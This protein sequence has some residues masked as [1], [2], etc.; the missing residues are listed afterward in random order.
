M[1][2]LT[3]VKVPSGWREPAWPPTRRET[4]TFSTANGDFD[5]NLTNGFPTTG[6]FGN[7]FLKLSTASGL[8]V[9]DYFEMDNQLQENSTDQDLGSGSVPLLPDLS[10]GAN[11]MHL[12]VGAGK[13]TNIYVVNRDS[14][15]KFNTSPNSNNVYQELPG[16]L[17]GG[18]WSMPAYFNNT[19][20]TTPRT[21][22]F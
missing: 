5:S 18:V 22:T 6:N 12:A 2:F 11:T 8:R 20:S 15:G 21:A 14:M 3:V 9:A 16:A 19:P 7:A 10:D 4:S 13:D 1:S 17:P